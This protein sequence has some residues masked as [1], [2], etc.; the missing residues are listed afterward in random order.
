M[1]QHEQERLIDA[2]EVHHPDH[3]V[4]VDSAEV[5]V[6]RQRVIRHRR[7]NHGPGYSIIRNRARGFDVLAIHT[8]PRPITGIGGV[9]TS[10]LNRTAKVTGNS[11]G[12]TLNKPAAPS[13]T[14]GCVSSGLPKRFP[15]QPNASNS[16]S[17]GCPVGTPEPF[18]HPSISSTR[19]MLHPSKNANASSGE[20]RCS[21]TRSRSAR[22]NLLWLTTTASHRS[23]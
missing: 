7:R 13:N 19:T 6:D 22:A 17:N 3:R 18:Q 5:I 23:E 21:R 14:N 9:R 12:F 11:A 20:A 2:A 4:G 1:P 8:R 10:R 15:C 16:P